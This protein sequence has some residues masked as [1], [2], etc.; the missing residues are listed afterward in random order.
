MPLSNV[1]PQF[2]LEHERFERCAMKTSFITF[3]M[4]LEESLAP[5]LSTGALSARSPRW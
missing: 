2:G 3:H 4:E 5:T 1:R